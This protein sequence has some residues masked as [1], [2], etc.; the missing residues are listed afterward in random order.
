[1]DKK[2]FDD[3]ESR[4][5]EV[6]KVIEKL[7]ASIRPAAFEFLKPY[8]T[9]G[10]IAAPKGGGGSSVSDDVDSAAAGDLDSLVKNHPDQKPNEN[11]KLLSAHWYSMYGSA[12]FTTKWIEETGAA[13]GLTIPSSVDMTFRQA[14]DKGKALYQALGKGGLLKPTVAGEHYLKAAYHV[15]K[16]T[17]TPPSNNSESQ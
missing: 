9:G 16:G 8:I 17:K 5:L 10:T 12:P 7:D 2:A 6:N 1:M 15:K 13:T 4:L 3:I 14:K 11:A